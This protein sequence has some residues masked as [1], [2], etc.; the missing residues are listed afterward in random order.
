MLGIDR[1]GLCFS[2]SDITSRTSVFDFLSRYFGPWEGIEE[3]P[4]TGSAHT[5]HAPYWSSN[6]ED[7]VPSFPGI[8]EGAN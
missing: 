3:D 7:P 4:L 2:G 5:V 8:E 6:T 1:G